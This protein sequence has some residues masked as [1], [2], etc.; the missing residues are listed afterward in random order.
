MNKS[1]QFNFLLL[2]TMIVLIFW[3]YGHFFNVYA[4]TITG[5]IFELLWFPIV[6]TT[7]FM[8][9]VT[10][11]F[12]CRYH[13]KINSKWFYLFLFSVLFLVAKIFFIG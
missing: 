7:F 8:P 5:A 4:F 2:M 3:A 6:L 10:L 11:F 9:L 1:L 13:F 12:W